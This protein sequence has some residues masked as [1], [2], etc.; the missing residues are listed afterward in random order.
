MKKT[1]LPITIIICS[2]S[3][4]HYTVPDRTVEIVYV[5][6]TDLLDNSIQVAQGRDAWKQQIEK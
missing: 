5:V 3:C 6:F 4:I 1:V 2:R